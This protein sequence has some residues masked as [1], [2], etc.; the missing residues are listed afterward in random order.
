MTHVGP[1]APAAS[2]IHDRGENLTGRARGTG[3]RFSRSGAFFYKNIA[4][5]LDASNWIR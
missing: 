2:R 1:G 5:R 4:P 3:L